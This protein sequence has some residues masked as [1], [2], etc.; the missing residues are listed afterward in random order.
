MGI[1]SWLR[2]STDEKIDESIPYFENKG[3]FLDEKELK[4]TEGEGVESLYL[5]KGGQ[6]TIGYYSM[7]DFYNNYISKNFE[8]EFMKIQEYRRMSDMAE[9]V[10]VVDD[11]VIEA[12]QKDELGKM[13]TMDIVDKDLKEDE[14]VNEILYEEFEDLFYR[15]IEL[16]KHFKD[17]FR[18]FMVDGRVF[19]E[20][21]IDL[22]NKND[23]IIRLKKLPAETMDYD[24]DMMTTTIKGFFQY[25]NP[26][27]KKVPN[28]E[29]AKK[30]AGVISFE[31]QQISFV[32][33]GQHGKTRKEIIGFL[34]KAKQPYNQLKLLE[35]SVVIYRL[36]RA[37]ERFVFK[38]D[39]GNMPRDKAEK[40]V[41]YQKRKFNQKMSFDPATG[42]LQNQQ[43]LLSMNESFFIAQGENRG[44]DI[45]TIG[46]QGTAGF[47]QLDDIKYFAIKLYRALKY[48][49]SRIQ[50]SFNGGESQNVFNFGGMDIPKDEIKWATF[51]QDYQNRFADVFKDLFIIHLDMK[52][53]LEKYKI[54]KSQFNF[55]FTAPNNYEYH[56]EQQILQTKVNGVQPLNMMQE[57]SKYILFTKYLGWTE[58]EWQE[59]VDGF[60]K[61]KTL[62]DALNKAM[63]FGGM[64]MPGMGMDPSM[65]GMPGQDPMMQQGQQQVPPGQGQGE[66][67]DDNPDNQPW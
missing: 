6:G 26:G 20:N 49:I 64:G 54:D 13:F 14:K 39:V 3:D 35:T 62:R 12:T 61:D 56:L 16:N 21:I 53:M 60:D 41:E 5:Y 46:G 9:I 29:E 2:G 22:N 51:L 65:G 43:D 36:V 42:T 27:G 18:S 63:G 66:T 48:P 8:D 30:I 38:I 23:G 67:E 24:Y 37:P 31:K 4:A 10:D 55:K 44:S 11:A 32:N 34:D 15:K 7:N 58:A 57:I 17:W 40:Y 33:T 28:M 59:N 1:L 52:G 25:L 50:N 19:L 45:T 47:T